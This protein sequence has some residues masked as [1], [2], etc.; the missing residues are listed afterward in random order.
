MS[1]HCQ[2]LIIFII[3]IFITAML[4]ACLDKRI[5]DGEEGRMDRQQQVGATRPIA[6]R[7]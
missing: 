2:V 1:V 6:A 3:I 7:G 4:V 5:L